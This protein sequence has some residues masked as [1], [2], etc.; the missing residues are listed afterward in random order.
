MNCLF[1]ENSSPDGGAILTQANVFI[2]GCYFD[3]NEGAEGGALKTSGWAVE[4]ANSVFFNNLGAE[5]GGAIYAQSDPLT[6]T[7]LPW[8]ARSASREPP[9]RDAQRRCVP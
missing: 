3:S 1:Q 8:G 6:L 9:G 5:R 2:T 7:L 4:V